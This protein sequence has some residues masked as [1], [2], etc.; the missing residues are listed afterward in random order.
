MLEASTVA[1]LARIR[2]VFSMATIETKRKK[3]VLSHKGYMYCFDRHNANDVNFW[4]CL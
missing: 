2:K 1:C 3:L 4:R